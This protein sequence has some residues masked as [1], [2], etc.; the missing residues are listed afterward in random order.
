[1][2]CFSYKK[3]VSL[4]E[5]ITP[6]LLE[7]LCP[8]NGKIYSATPFHSEPSTTESRRVAAAEAA[9][10]P[11][12]SSSESR[13]VARSRGENY[14]D[15]PR[16]PHMSPIPGSV[17]RFSSIPAWNVA[18]GGSSPAEVT[19]L[20][21]DHSNVITTL[22]QSYPSE[23]AIEQAILG[24]VQFAFVCFLVGQVKI[25]SEISCSII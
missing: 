7:H 13:R 2:F 8:L 25:L 17:I 18:P 14:D 20:G 16:L 4:T 12:S 3:W 15:D 23:L 24:E 1:V 22:I 21:L 5:H 19:R 10:H 11:P 9:C 6:V